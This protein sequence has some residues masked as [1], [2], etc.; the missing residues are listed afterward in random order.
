MFYLSEIDEMWHGR[1]AYTIGP[2]WRGKFD[3]DQRR[4]WVWKPTN[5]KMW[6][7]SRYLAVFRSTRATLYSDQADIWQERVHQGSTFAR[8]IRP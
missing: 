7:K 6:S 2:L 8:Q 4:R 5:F 1:V 3:S